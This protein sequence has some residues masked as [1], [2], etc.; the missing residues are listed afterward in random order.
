VG[1]EAGTDCYLNCSSGCFSGCT[2]G[3]AP[4]EFQP[5]N[6]PADLLVAAG[7]FDHDPADVLVAALRREAADKAES[8]NLPDMLQAQALV[9]LSAEAKEEGNDVEEFRKVLEQSNVL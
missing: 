5:R 4:L 8:A 1:Q 9:G 6:A 2:D 7:E 3:N